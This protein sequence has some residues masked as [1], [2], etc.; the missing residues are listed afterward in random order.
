MQI[1]LQEI[2]KRILYK[3]NLIADYVIEYG[4][5]G[6]WEYEKWASGK[7]VCRGITSTSVTKWTAWGNLYE[8]NPYLG[9]TLFPT[10]LFIEAPLF[11]VAVTSN[12]GLSA[13]E[14]YLAITKDKTPAIYPLRP[15]GGQSAPAYYHME[16]TGKWK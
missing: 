4:T 12:Q 10:G 14:T 13:M 3:F 5:D 1:H 2:L 16:A 11:K 9:Q 6:I 8:G 7:A 15:A